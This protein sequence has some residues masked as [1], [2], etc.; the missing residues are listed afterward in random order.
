MAGINEFSVAVAFTAGPLVVSPTWTYLDAV[1]GI[2]V[3]EWTISRGRPDELQKTSTGTATV[4]IADLNGVFDPTN[5]ASAYFPDVLPD[6]QAMI[7]LYDP[8][9]ATW[10]TLFRG[11]IDDIDYDVQSFTYDSGAVVHGVLFVTLNLVDAFGWLNDHELM[12]G[13]AGDPPP[14]GSE[15]R[16]FYEDTAGSVGDRITA[17]L[18]DVGWPSGL[19]S[20][21]S[22]NVKV[23]ETVYEPGT[24]AL[25]ALFDAADAEFPGVANLFVK[26]DGTVTFH[27]RQARFRPDVAGYGINR[28]DVGDPSVTVSDATICPISELQFSLG[29]TQLYNSVLV[30]PQDKTVGVPPTDTDIAAQL[31]EDSTSIT[32]HGKKG[33]TFTDLLTVEGIATGNTALQETRLM[34][35]YYRDNYKDPLPRITRMVF[36]SR[37]PSERLA[38][39]LWK[40]ICRCEISD[41]LSVT[42]AHVGG[43]GFADTGNQGYYVEGI[44]YTCRPASTRVHDVRLEV[45]V[46]PQAL[47]TNNPFDSDHDP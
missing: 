42:T 38:D 28:R 41:L 3:Q 11:Y 10:H 18:A 35:T 36:K 23:T 2:R 4:T 31:L 37:D 44:R 45:D 33:L 24:T 15:G 27:G 32:A 46:S 8:V 7:R 25:A 6:R 16:V 1:A 29:K 12:P 5:G 17:V 19:S 30:V 39:P 43:G 34:A 22:G 13:V 26:T 40:M 14:T 21:F 47:F 9:D 20:V